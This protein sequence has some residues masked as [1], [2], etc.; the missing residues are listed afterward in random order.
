HAHGFVRPYLVRTFCKFM[1]FFS[2]TAKCT[3]DEHNLTLIMN[4]PEIRG[5]IPP[6]HLIIMHDPNDESET[7]YF[8]THQDLWAVASSYRLPRR[9]PALPWN[10]L[11][12]AH[13]IGTV[14][15]PMAVLHTLLYGIILPPE[16]IRACA[17]GARRLAVHFRMP[18]I[19]AN[20]GGLKNNT[21]WEEDEVDSEEDEECQH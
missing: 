17:D 14:H 2:Y 20:I 21:F 12:P 9:D 5:F 15:G 8:P 18:Y 1:M 7:S 19:V 13:L 6:T 3:C 16:E 10:R 11:V 4:Q